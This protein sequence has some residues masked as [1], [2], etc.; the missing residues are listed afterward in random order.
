MEGDMSKA[1]GGNVFLFPGG[2]PPGGSEPLD[3]ALR[4]QRRRIG[5]IIEQMNK[6]FSVCNDH[7]TVLI[8][9]EVEDK[10]RPGYCTAG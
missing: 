5:R 1:D 9:Q 10:L 3:L 8:F 4:E 7:G 6:S 2:T